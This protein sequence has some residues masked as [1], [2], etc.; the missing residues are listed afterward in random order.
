MGESEKFEEQGRAHAAL[1]EA[2]ST[3][4]TLTVSLRQYAE[5]LIG[6]GA[7]INRYVADP[8]KLD[9]GAHKPQFQNLAE[10]L[11]RLQ[12]ETSSAI[13]RLHDIDGQATRVQLLQKQVDQF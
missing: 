3:V 6:L 13:Q 1:R 12:D 8:G 7:E 4:A 9:P 10:H 5:T 11:Q 2:R